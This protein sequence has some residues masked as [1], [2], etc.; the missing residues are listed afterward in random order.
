MQDVISGE[1]TWT[2]PVA[3]NTKAF[4][5]DGEELAIFEPEGDFKVLRL[6][7]G[8]ELI[9]VEDLE[10]EQALQGI[11]VNRSSRQYVLVTNNKTDKRVQQLRRAGIQAH[12]P[13]FSGSA[14]PQVTGHVYA[15]DRETGKM[16]W[17]GPAE[18]ADAFF[19]PSQPA[20]APVLAFV[21]NVSRTAAPDDGNRLARRVRATNS[22]SLFC[23]DLRDGSVAYANHALEQAQV[24]RMT[25]S[26]NEQTVS[27]QLRTSGRNGTGVLLTLTEIPR[28]AGKPAVFP[29]LELDSPPSPEVKDKNDKPS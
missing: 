11:Y 14:A 29:P 4:V 26:P 3:K 7:D 5:I 15:V 24:F 18:V 27:I 2:L 1:N 25:A 19:P 23:I 21:R 22:A 10:E 13:S 12:A 28:P 9:H 8:Q 6:R 20:E 17:S 16:G